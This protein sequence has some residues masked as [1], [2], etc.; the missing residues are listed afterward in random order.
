[1]TSLR[2][3]PRSLT[4]GCECGCRKQDARP[5]RVVYEP[6]TQHGLSQQRHMTASTH[7]VV[8]LTYNDA[9]KNTKLDLRLPPSGTTKNVQ[10]QR[11]LTPYTDIHRSTSW[12][13]TELGRLIGHLIRIS[14]NK[15]I[16]SIRNFTLNTSLRGSYPGRCLQSGGYKNP[17]TMVITLDM[18]LIAELLVVY[19]CSTKTIM[20]ST[21]YD[22]HSSRNVST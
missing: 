14:C 10:L 11:F 9:H 21:I 20:L 19:G 6:V 16:C 3:V 1:M 2:R 8:G 5:W 7:P 15:K 12:F 18:S 17:W 13:P 4:A 22:Y